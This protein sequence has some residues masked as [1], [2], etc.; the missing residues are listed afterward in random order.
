LATKFKGKIKR[1]IRL[2]DVPTPVIVTLSEEGVEMSVP[3]SRTH[4]S[5]S[6]EVVARAMQTSSNVPSVMF[7]QPIKLLQQ[8]A[9]K[10][11]AKKSAA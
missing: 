4:V 9:N 1:E 3:G 10:A 11:L 7:G 5:A 6:W 8:Q 2:W